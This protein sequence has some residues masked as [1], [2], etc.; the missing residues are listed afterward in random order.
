MV[1]IITDTSTLYTKEEADHLNI[2]VNPLMVNLKGVDY[3]DYEDIDTA[4]FCEI[5]KEGNV[6]KSSQPPVGM[7]VEAY[8][9]TDEDVINITIA[10]GL[11]GTYQSALGAWEMAKD[12]ERVTVL[13]SK[14]I[15]GPE[16]YNVGLAAEL[17]KAG[18]AKDEILKR[19][20]ESLSDVH[21]F[22]I[23]VDVDFLKRGRRLTPIAAT[24]GGFL[25][26]VPV[27]IQSDD[28]KKI[29]KYHMSRTMNDAFN[30]ILKYFEKHNV[31]EDHIIYVS[32]AENHLNAMNAYNKIKEKYPNNQ[33][34][35]LE[36]SPAFVTQGGPG[37]I[38]IQYIKR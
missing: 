36:L 3:R 18:Q 4:K 30:S 24:V 34:E 31:N 6:P 32:H 38:A 1:K 7:V 25:K 16:R 28:G 26:I 33:V 12:K 2:I 23:P 15:C 10:D 21:S 11:S 14:T 27:M 8:D 13:N 29:G 9:S 5:V 22:L 35:M 19:L 17:A 37:C 20:D